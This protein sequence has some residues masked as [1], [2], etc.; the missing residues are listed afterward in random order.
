MNVALR[1]DHGADIS[2]VFDFLHFAKFLTVRRQR[3]IGSNASA[4]KNPLA[5]QPCLKTLAMGNCPL[6][7]PANSTCVVLLQ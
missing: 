2:G 6:V 5:G 3:K 1:T 4:K 7:L